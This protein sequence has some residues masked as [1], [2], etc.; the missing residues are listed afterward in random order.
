MT[1]LVTGGTAE[2]TDGFGS[3]RAE[4]A[5]NAA[6]SS[7]AIGIAV[8]HDRCDRVAARGVDSGF[9]CVVAAGTMKD[10]LAK[11][12]DMNVHSTGTCRYFALTAASL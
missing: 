1:A 7:A 12:K 9:A 5:A 4:P 10:L 3:S 2:S 6:I 8:L 11:A